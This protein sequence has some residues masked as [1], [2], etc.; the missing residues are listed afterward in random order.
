MIAGA[1]HRRSL[2]RSVV[3]MPILFLALLQKGS[4]SKQKFEQNCWNWVSFVQEIM[5]I[6]VAEVSGPNPLVSDSFWPILP[7]LKFIPAPLGVID[8]KT[9]WEED[10]HL[11]SEVKNHP[12]QPQQCSSSSIFNGGR[13]NSHRVEELLLLKPYIRV[14]FP[15]GSNYRL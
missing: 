3:F 8:K 15:V 13:P 4:S 5:K 14:R 6:F 12:C 11:Y 2:W 9:S 10:F 1:S 7:L